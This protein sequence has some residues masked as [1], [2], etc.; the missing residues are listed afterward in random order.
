MLRV[1]EGEGRKIVRARFDAATAQTLIEVDEH[2]TRLRSVR[3]GLA[4]LRLAT[5]DTGLQPEF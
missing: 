3:S 5:H 1:G 2:G 4:L